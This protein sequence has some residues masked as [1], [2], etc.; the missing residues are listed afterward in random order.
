MKAKSILVT[1]SS[2]F[3]GSYLIKSLAAKKY[4]ITEF[5]HRDGDIANTKLKFKNIDHVFH[6]AGK[7][8][9]PD[10]WKNPAEFYYVNVMGALNILEFCRHNNAALT[11]ISSY[12][13]GVPESN[14][15][16][17][18]HPINPSNPYAH[19]KFIAEETCNYYRKNF[20]VRMAVIRP[21]NIYGAG[22]NEKFLI[23]MIIK[24]MLDKSCKRI[25]VMDLKPKR[26]YIY[27]R[28]LINA[29]IMLFEHDT[30][31]TFNVG[32]GTSL[33]VEEVIRKIFLITGIEK[34]I[35]VK[36]EERKNEIPEVTADISK[37]RKEINWHP[38]YSFEEGLREIIK[39]QKMK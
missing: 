13:Y 12:V 34:E 19:S 31:D 36:Q 24:Q 6:L 20:N 32:S 30:F 39:K 10:S 23:P 25:E 8:F 29:M 35:S 28:D 3:I 5:N 4:K 26:D 22:Q 37:I 16:S 1:G 33:S 14:P 17:E 18:E 7:S 15:V 9:V 38:E 2:G 11:F 21:F 27:I